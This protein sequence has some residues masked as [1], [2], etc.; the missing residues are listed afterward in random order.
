MQYFAN[1]IELTT[2]V[3]WTYGSLSSTDWGDV[4]V[5]AVILLLVSVYYVLHRWDYNA[6]LSGEEIA[7]S[8]GI[9]VKRLTMS[10]MV[11]AA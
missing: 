1:E 9:N 10:N 6:L 2:L 11:L 7:V 5:M 3:F 8:L 4:G